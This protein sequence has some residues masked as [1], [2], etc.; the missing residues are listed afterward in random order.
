MDA[1]LSI[2]GTLFLSGLVGSLGHCLGMCGPLVI[3]VGYQLKP[4]GVAL[5]PYYLLY[6][7]ARI[8]VYAVLGMI[9]GLI[10]S[11]LGLGDHLGR[12]GGIISLA[13]GLA[14]VLFGLSY[15]GWLPGI[16]VENA[17]QRLSKAMSFALR[18]GGPWG[19]AILGVLNGL[20][21]CGLVYG[22]L[23][24]AIST[25]GPLT[26]GLG[27]LIFGAGTIPALLILGVG[28][29]SLGVRTRQAFARL[30]GLLI[31]IIGVQLALRGMA[32]LSVLP[33]L[34]LG[35]LMLW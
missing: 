24:V 34:K 4:H 12:L 21:P 10:G 23:L 13:L 33:H 1:N 28:A 8:T 11:M 25:G 9:A 7:A 27:M 16:R 15:L 22:A 19:V 20:L 30:A 6:H 14:T 35:E 5:L 29:A 32:G 26:G 2:F 3:M 31:V 18:R 17:S